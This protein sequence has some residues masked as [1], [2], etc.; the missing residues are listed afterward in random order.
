LNEAGKPLAEFEVNGLQIR[1]AE[2]RY[3]VPSHGGG[4]LRIRA[5][6]YMP[7][8]AVVHG[9]PGAEVAVPDITLKPARAVRVHV[10]D[11]VTGRPVP[12]ARAVLAFF[13]VAPMGPKVG[14]ELDELLQR[15]Q[16]ESFDHIQRSAMLS[17]IPRA[18]SDRNGDFVLTEL[19][20]ET[21]RLSVLHAGY[22]EEM[23]ELDPDQTEIT[24]R[25]KPARR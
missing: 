10:R 4:E 12:N 24:V 17:R 6:G 1:N 25:L 16:E 14:E 23:L 2:G 11:A 3:R 13:T 21:L 22:V 7:V 5:P 8:G 18:P 15:H 20:D 19:P 9:P